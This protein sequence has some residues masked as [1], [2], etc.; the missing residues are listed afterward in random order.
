VSTKDEGS[1]LLGA[2]IKQRLLKIPQAGEDLAC[3][4]L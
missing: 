4:V 1:P 3:S 2:V